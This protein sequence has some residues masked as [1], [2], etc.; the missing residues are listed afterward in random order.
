MPTK[1]FDRCLRNL[2]TV[3]GVACEHLARHLGVP[4]PEVRRWMN[5]TAAPDIY[6]FQKIARFF[7]LPCEWFLDNGDSFPD[8][9][10]LAELLGLNVDTLEGL[11]LLAGTENENVLEPLD[12]AIFAIVSSFRT[13]LE[14]AEYGDSYA[15]E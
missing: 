9:E 6:Q 7:S 12:E 13:I 1:K 3:S 5:G 15:A 8:V 11:L 10:D 2:L 14:R 4:V